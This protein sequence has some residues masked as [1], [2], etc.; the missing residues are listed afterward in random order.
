MALNTN[1]ARRLLQVSSIYSGD[2]NGRKLYVSSF[3][4][5]SFA[6]LEC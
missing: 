5:N 1:V 3:G 4:Q 2:A 6:S